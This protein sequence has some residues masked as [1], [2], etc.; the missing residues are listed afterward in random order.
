MAIR[1]SEA[2]PALD[3][4]KATPFTTQPVDRS[5]YLARRLS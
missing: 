3:A 1:G 5:L 4:R 2:H